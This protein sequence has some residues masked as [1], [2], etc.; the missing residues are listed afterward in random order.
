MWSECLGECLKRTQRWTERDARSPSLSSLRESQ[1]KVNGRVQSPEIFT[2]P[3]KISR[4][5]DIR[6]DA[7]GVAPSWLVGAGR[8]KVPRVEQGWRKSLRGTDKFERTQQRV[9]E[10]VEKAASDAKRARKMET[11]EMTG[12]P[13]D[14]AASSSTAT[15]SIHSG[16]GTTERRRNLMEGRCDLEPEFKRARVSSDVGMCAVDEEDGPVDCKVSDTKTG[17]IL[18]LRMM[19][20]ARS[21]ETRYMDDI[22]MFEDATDEECLTNT[23]KPPVD[24]VGGRQ[25]RF[26]PGSR[27]PKPT[28]CNGFQSKR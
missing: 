3:R 14:N 25:Q 21:E 10:P 13:H 1:F 2:S 16:M 11:E 22:G 28:G 24:K 27:G 15:T 5:T 17:D 9:N 23:G 4:R 26:S 6:V 18:V 19:A 12:I 7:S 8:A 20:A